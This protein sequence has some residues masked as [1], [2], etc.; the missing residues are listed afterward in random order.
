MK[1]V[2]ALFAGSL[3]ALLATG[4]SFAQSRATTGDTTTSQEPSNSA[5]PAKKPSMFS[6][7][8]RVTGEVVAADPAA[9]TLTVKDSKG[10]EYAFSAD[11]DAATRLGD[12]R[13]GDRVKVDYKKSKGQMV[14]TKIVEAKESSRATK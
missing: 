2:T 13:V 5:A 11:S 3:V 14:A 8:H 7:P 4:P 1:K 9:N 6:M 10:K 12:L